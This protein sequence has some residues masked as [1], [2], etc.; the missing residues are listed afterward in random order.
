[1][2]ELTNRPTTFEVQGRVERTAV[3]VVLVDSS[4][5]VL[6]L[7]TRDAS[8]PAFGVSWE[9]PGGG[10][11][12]KEGVAEAAV[13]EVRE[14]TGVRILLSDVGEP[15]WHREVFYTYRGEKRLQRESVCV[16]R[17]AGTAPAIDVTGRETVEME[18]HLLH[19][20]WRVDEMI[21]SKDRFYPRRLPHYI[22]A[23]L[24]G[25]KIVDPLESW[26]EAHS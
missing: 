25:H 13:R 19:R 8:N 14:E 6:L 18:D 24:A 15:L 11:A 22:D 10:I 21:T 12:P 16:A 17:I 7:S 1:M 9:L 3:R 4:G 23:L 20:W 5:S 2:R 26:D